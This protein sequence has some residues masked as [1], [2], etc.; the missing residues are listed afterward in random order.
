M[1]Y[2]VPILVNE[3]IDKL[4][5]KKDGT[6][7]DCTL[8]FG[9][10]SEKI[11][12]KLSNKGRII[13]MDLDP[14][15]LET[16]KEKLKEKCNIAFYNNSYKDFPEIL[17]ENNIKE[18]DGF[19]FDLGISS[20]Q[21]DSEHRGFSYR[22]DSPLNMKFNP[23][24]S[25]FTAKELVNYASEKELSEIIKK[26]GEERYHR[27][28]AKKIVEKRKKNK[29]ETTFDLKNIIFSAVPFKSPKI[30]SRVFQSLRIAVNDEIN[31]FRNS[32]AESV[33]FLKIGGRVAVISF[34]SIEDRIVKHFFKNNTMNIEEK[35]CLK[36][37]TKKPIIAQYEEIK[38]NRRS[39]SAK[40]RVA[41]RI[42]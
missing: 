2:H 25:D 8:G 16:A 14:Y 20:Y 10:H 9:G 30:L 32:L 17:N 28:I 3:T 22:F 11:A 41:E 27:R 24:D 37:L 7:I 31:T 40:L 21:V 33:K 34:H 6:Y 23:N 19:L 38:K 5:I 35:A 12:K 26:Y 39:K 4:N 13:G 42:A 18:V 15:A 1:V 29:I 36:I